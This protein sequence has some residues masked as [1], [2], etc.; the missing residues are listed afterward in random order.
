MNRPIRVLIADRDVS[1][2]K[3]LEAFLNTQENIKVVDLVRDGQGAVNRCKEA[4]PDLVLMDLHLP[5]LDSIRAIQSIVAQNERV[6]ILG[7]SSI[8]NDR[9]AVEAIKAG[10][11]GYIQKNGN[12]EDHSVI[13]TAIR[14]VANGEVILNPVLASY[15][16]REFH[17]LDE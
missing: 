11:R 3:S 17:K 8:P 7:I 10:A 14:Q 6:K 13:V 2:S 12:G 16:L 4:L 1:F 9:Y 15:I 5:V